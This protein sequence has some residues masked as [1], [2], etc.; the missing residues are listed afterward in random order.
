M[1]VC[2]CVCVCVCGCVCVCVCVC[3]R[4]VCLLASVQ[5]TH[6]MYTKRL[7]FVCVFHRLSFARKRKYNFHQKKILENNNLPSTT[8]LRC[9]HSEVYGLSSP[10]EK[11]GCTDAVDESSEEGENYDRHVQDGLHMEESQ[12]RQQHA[13]ETGQGQG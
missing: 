13:N 3:V 8:P 7:H 5:D 6:I 1:H 4:V 12:R 10:D 9:H 11:E 2:V